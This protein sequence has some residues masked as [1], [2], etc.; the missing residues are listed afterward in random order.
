MGTVF[1]SLLV[2]SVDF[3]DDSFCDF[4]RVSKARVPFVRV[5]WLLLWQPAWDRGT[6]FFFVEAE[7]NEEMIDLL[8]FPLLRPVHGLPFEFDSLGAS[9]RPVC[10]AN[11][12]HP[13]LF[14]FTWRIND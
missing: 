10:P 8:A 1:R 12:L 6:K 14:L 2:S 4:C 7:K 9:L 5:F 13:S 3:T 11:V